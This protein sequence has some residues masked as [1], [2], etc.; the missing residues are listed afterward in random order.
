MILSINIQISKMLNCTINVHQHDV[1]VMRCNGL[2]QTIK[3]E[4]VVHSL[5]DKV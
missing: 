3:N 2:T 4:L 1:N 5:S